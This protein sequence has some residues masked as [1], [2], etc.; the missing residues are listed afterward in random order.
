M[1]TRGANVASPLTTHR[2]SSL[3]PSPPLLQFPEENNSTRKRG[4]PPSFE[5]LTT[6]WCLVDDPVFLRKK[7][8]AGP[9]NRDGDPCE[10]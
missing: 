10:I 6:L 8:S 4:A 9:L 5:T 3:P 1:A 2:R 7:R